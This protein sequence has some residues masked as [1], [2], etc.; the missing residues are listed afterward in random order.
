MIQLI[1]IKSECDI[2]TR[3]KFS[4]I[5]SKLENNLGYIK[6]AI[7]DVVILSTC[8]R[9]EVYVDSDFRKEDLIDRMF[10]ILEW[11]DDLMISTFYVEGRD[12]V[13]H[14][15]EVS[16]G[17][18][19]RILGEDQ[20]LGQIKSAYESAL[21]AGAVKGRL[22][23]LF[24]STIACGKKFKS[25]CRMY[26]IPVSVPSIAVKEARSR[27]LK[28]YMI[29]GF[30]QIGQLVLKYLISASVEIIYVVVRDLNRFSS[31][32]SEYKRVKFIT[33]KEKKS[34]YE[35]VDCI[36]SCT[37]APH[38][39]IGKDELPFRNIVIFDLA[40][41]RDVNVNVME[42]PNIKLYDIDNISR[43]DEKNKN[44][45]RKKMMEYR[46]I[47]FDYID[48]FMKWQSIAELSPEIQNIKKQGS[49]I[50][51]RRINTFI[52]KR[53]TKDNEKLVKRMVESTARFYIDRAIEVLK[54]EKLKG[55][56]IECMNIINRIFCNENYN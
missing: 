52:N 8:N 24:Q 4:I 20:I 35:D 23:R 46:Y 16:C 33:F 12:A 15:M 39:I 11:D 27:K 36:I 14:L 38:V 9:T 54:E 6:N 40:V 55:K 18:H 21:K 42:L 37:S 49:V 25:A 47:T 3:Q 13:K 44:I 32:E 26:E 7:G 2:E 53:H 29:V 43:I 56:E 34:Y 19:S 28:R 30:G 31:M 48:E 50:C 10:E 51:D 45:R 17:F 22:H 41:P 1:G 5:P